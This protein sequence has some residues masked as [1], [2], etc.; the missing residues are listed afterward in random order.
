MDSKKGV[1]GLFIGLVII[2]IFMAL[3]LS[4][5]IDFVYRP[6]PESCQTVDFEIIK[7]CREGPSIRLTII[8]RGNLDFRFTANDQTDNSYFIN[9]SD[10]KIFTFQNQNNL[11]LIPLAREG[12]NNYLQCRA[13]SESFK[14][15]VLLV[16]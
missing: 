11:K 15:E 6:D 9:V 7:S 16:C 5:T 8:N 14:R 10:Q 4:T 2:S 12:I 1:S 13:K 3:I